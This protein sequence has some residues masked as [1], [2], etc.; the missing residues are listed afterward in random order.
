MDIGSDIWVYIMLEARLVSPCLSFPSSAKSCF[1]QLAASSG[2]TAKLLEKL[3]LAAIVS[4]R[5]E[6]KRI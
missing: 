4:L 5:E 2:V 3:E 6:K 1:L